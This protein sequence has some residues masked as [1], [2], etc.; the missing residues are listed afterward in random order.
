[1]TEKDAN[2]L[3]RVVDLL[4]SG[5]WRDAGACGPYWVLRHGEDPLPMLVPNELHQQATAA[6]EPEDAAE[7]PEKP[8]RSLG[9]RLA[10][11]AVDT[12]IRDGAREHDHYIYGTPRKGEAR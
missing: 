11:L 10:D 4:R 8:E 3:R 9:Q 7:H 5:R 1:M 2:L 6:D 12:G